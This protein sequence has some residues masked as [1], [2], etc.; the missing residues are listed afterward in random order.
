MKTFEQ[1]VKKLILNKYGSLKHFT[2]TIQM[3]WTTLDS[4]LKRGIANS[5]VSNVSKI[6]KE[7]NLDLE[8]FIEGKLLSSSP[9]TIAAHKDSENWTPEEYQKIE[10]YKQLLLAARSIKQNQRPHTLN[11]SQKSA[12]SFDHTPHTEN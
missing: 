8:A 10:D 5:N 1:E 7:L 11:P 4:I 6:A 12:Y 2:D 3:P 9:M